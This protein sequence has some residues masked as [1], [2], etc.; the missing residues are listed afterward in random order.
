MATFYIH[1]NQRSLHIDIELKR[2]FGD[3]GVED[4]GVKDVREVGAS[5]CNER[6]GEVV[7]L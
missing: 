6:K 2:G 4:L 5:F 1:I 7:G 3:M